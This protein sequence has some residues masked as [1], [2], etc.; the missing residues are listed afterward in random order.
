MFS[1]KTKNSLNKASG[2]W[3]FA[4]GAGL[5]VWG[6]SAFVIYLRACIMSNNL[7]GGKNDV[8]LMLISVIIPGL[9]YLFAG[10]SAFQRKKWWLA[11]VCSIILCLVAF[12]SGLTGISWYGIVPV[13][14]LSLIAAILLV[15]SK[16]NFK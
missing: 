5:T 2:I 1:T 6:I 14:F 9:L 11:L 7:V 3:L 8:T 13:F 12:W 4:V 10:Y 15:V 16:D